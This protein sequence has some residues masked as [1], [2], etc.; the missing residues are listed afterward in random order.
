MDIEKSLQSDW[1]AGHCILRSLIRPAK[2]GKMVNKTDNGDKQQ[3]GDSDEANRAFG[4][5]ERLQK[6]ESDF[7]RW[8]PMKKGKKM[9]TSRPGRSA[10][11]IPK[12]KKGHCEYVSRR[13]TQTQRKGDICGRIGIIRKDGTCTCWLHLNRARRLAQL[14]I[15]RI[16]ANLQKPKWLKKLKEMLEIGVQEI[17]KAHL[18]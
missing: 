3:K 16:K 5:A 6:L 13:R 12:L 2:K 15:S 18:N 10:N 8:K 1:L 17:Q 7:Y 4:Q 14:R 9:R 11:Y